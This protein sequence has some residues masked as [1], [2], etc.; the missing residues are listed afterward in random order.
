MVSL[1]LC[2]LVLGTG[3]QTLEREF[4][5]LERLELYH[6][7]LRIFSRGAR[8]TMLYNFVIPGHFWLVIP[9]HCLLIIPGH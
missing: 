4:E 1:F 6:D 8:I 2:K 5:T 3:L 7:E 9:G